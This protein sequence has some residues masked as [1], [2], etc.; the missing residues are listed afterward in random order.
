MVGK[1][2]NLQ[3]EVLSRE[4]ECEKGRQVYT[5][6]VKQEATC[7]LSLNSDAQPVDS[8]RGNGMAQGLLA[9]WPPGWLASEIY[10]CLSSV[11]VVEM[12]S[13]ARLGRETNVRRGHDMVDL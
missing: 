10:G 1:I 8:E 4:S 3:D 6:Q 12:G 11:E 5:E 7:S 2:T 9:G 13:S